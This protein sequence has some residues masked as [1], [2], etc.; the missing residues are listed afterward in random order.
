MWFGGTRSPFSEAPT[1]TGRGRD[2]SWCCFMKNTGTAA[3]SPLPTVPLTRWREGS[4]T[5]TG[6][7]ELEGGSNLPEGGRREGAAARRG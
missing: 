6:K 1:Q 7:E 2:L 3:K 5:F 4:A